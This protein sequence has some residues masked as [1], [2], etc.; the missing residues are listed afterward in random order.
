MPMSFSLDQACTVHKILSQRTHETFGTT[1]LEKVKSPRGGRNKARKIHSVWSENKNHK[2]S[3]FLE[4][5]SRITLPMPLLHKTLTSLTWLTSRKARL[6]SRFSGSHPM[7]LLSVY[8]LFQSSFSPTSVP[9]LSTYLHRIVIKVSPCICQDGRWQE[10]SV[11]IPS[12]TQQS[13]LIDYMWRWLFAS[14]SVVVIV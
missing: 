13:N 1:D 7:R 14:Y 11:L 8:M 9:W 6:N 12:A 3:F 10:A 5:I 4:E 2:N